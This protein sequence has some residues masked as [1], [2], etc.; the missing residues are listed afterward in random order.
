MTEEIII[1]AENAVLGRLASYAA[2][3]ALLGKNIVIVN[4][5]KAIIVCKEKDIV[6]RYARKRARG[7]WGLSGPNFPSTPDRILK[8][9]IRNMLPI[10]K[11]RG[12]EALKRVKCYLGLAGFEGKK[13]IKSGK[14]KQGVSLERI[15]KLLRGGK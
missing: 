8:R 12:K 5:E 9:T 1:N 11:R 13:M 4:S 6:E 3:Q 10:R 2:K 15:S 14:G 7:G